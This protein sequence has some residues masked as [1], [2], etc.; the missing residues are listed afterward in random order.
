MAKEVKVVN[1]DDNKKH[2]TNEK[3]QKNE[4]RKRRKTS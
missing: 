2:G 4:K 1:T 3:N